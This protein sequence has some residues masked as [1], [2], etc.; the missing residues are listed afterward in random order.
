MVYKQNIAIQQGVEDTWCY[1]QLPYINE[2]RKKRGK[3]NE[4][5]QYLPKHPPENECDCQHQH[6]SEQENTKSYTPE[7]LI[8]K[9]WNRLKN[10]KL[11]LY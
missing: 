8:Y 4:K 11:T 5:E 6:V 3:A 7:R 10:P 1:P 9:D 2:R